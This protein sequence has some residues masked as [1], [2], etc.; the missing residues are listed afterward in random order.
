MHRLQW[1]WP[2]V[3]GLALVAVHHPYHVEP[4]ITADNH[5]I[6]GACACNVHVHFDRGVNDAGKEYV[7]PHFFHEPPMHL[8]VATGY[9]DL[10]E[11]G[12]QP[13]A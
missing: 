4:L 5:I 12:G 13:P 9:L 7:F 10:S 6:L 2:R 1:Y 11:R 3:G 8:F